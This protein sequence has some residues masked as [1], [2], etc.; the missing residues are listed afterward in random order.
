MNIILTWKN[1]HKFFKRV[2][3][4]RHNVTPAS[5]QETGQLLFPITP[6]QAKV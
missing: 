2:E 6:P 3:G 5:S 4:S 1:M